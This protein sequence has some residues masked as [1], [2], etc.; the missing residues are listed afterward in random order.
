MVIVMFYGLL[1]GGCINPSSKPKTSDSGLPVKVEAMLINQL[2]PE[3][4]G[5]AVFRRGINGLRI[6]ASGN[7]ILEFP[8]KSYAPARVVVPISTEKY[9]NGACTFDVND[10]GID[11]MIVGRAGKLEGTDLLWFEELPGQKLWK[12]HLIANVKGKEGDAEKGFHDI[13]PFEV[14]VSDKT[15][16]GVA[17]LVSRKRLYW[18]EIPEDV[19]Q[20]WKEH[21]ITDLGTHG[22]KYA[23]SGLVPGDIAGNGRLDLVCGNFWA[24]CPADPATDKW[25]IRRYSNWDTRSTPRFPEVPAWVAD[26][27]FGGM[28]QLDLGDMD[29]DGKLDIVATDAE[30]PEARVGIFCRDITNPLGLWKETIIDTATYCP[31]SLV[32]A[33]VNKDQRPDII[34]GEMTA[35]GWWFPRNPDPHLYLYLNL[36]NMKFEKHILYTGWGVHMMRNAMLPT[37]DSIFVFAADEIQSWYEDM[38]THVVGW[39]VQ[40]ACSNVQ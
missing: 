24:E 10:D 21:I 25:Q 11:E 15:V 28:N 20:P 37:N 4:F 18:F 40:P 5:N 35:G 19:T 29:G 30:I 27:H 33:D 2:G 13:M 23:Q 26:E 32:V 3:H 12:E 9:T 34:V 31:H 39:T 8:V 7:R 14:K 1:I 36:G 16:R 6:A 22:A 38:T 17:A